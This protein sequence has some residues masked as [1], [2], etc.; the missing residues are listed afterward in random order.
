MISTSFAGYGLGKGNHI[1]QFHPD[2]PS[3][4]ARILCFTIKM[5]RGNSD[6]F[7]D[8][9]RGKIFPKKS[10]TRPPKWSKNI[11]DTVTK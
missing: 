2:C 6:P 4:V 11:G 1:I 3:T 5:L 8:L 9:Q 10:R 7:P